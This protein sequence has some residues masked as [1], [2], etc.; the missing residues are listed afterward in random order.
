MRRKVLFLAMGIGVASVACEQVS[1]PI[2]DE[3]QHQFS[4]AAGP[5]VESVCGSAHFTFRGVTWRT[6][7]VNARKYDDGSVRGTFQ[8]R[9][10]GGAWFKGV[11]ACFT[12]NENRAWLGAVVEATNAG[13]P[14]ST[15]L[16]RGIYVED[17]CSC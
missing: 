12:N 6:S 3:L 4:M 5:V 17:R 10:H 2:A 16:E 7:S 9:C 8:A 13:P 11:I 1:E 15:D 14:Q